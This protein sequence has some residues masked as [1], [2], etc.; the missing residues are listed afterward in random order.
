MFS[1]PDTE[2]APTLQTT[3]ASDLSYVAASALHGSAAFVAGINCRISLAPEMP[4]S[5]ETPT[6]I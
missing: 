6:V 5:A 3:I 2:A 4:L 1:A